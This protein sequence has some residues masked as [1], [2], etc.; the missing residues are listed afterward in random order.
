MNFN[1][2]YNLPENA[3]FHS[4][5]FILDISRF[6]AVGKCGEVVYLIKDNAILCT[7]IV[8]STYANKATV[9]LD[10]PE[11][12]AIFKDDEY[13]KV[14][15][16]NA[17]FPFDINTGWYMFGIRQ[18]SEDRGVGITIVSKTNFDFGIASKMRYGHIPGFRA[19]LNKN[20]G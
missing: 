12:L 3:D 4:D 20:Q 8:G 5:E 11:A 17:P 2:E 6:P 16:K 9:Y 7:G 19:S 14:L 1:A 15:G 10:N 13:V 18:E